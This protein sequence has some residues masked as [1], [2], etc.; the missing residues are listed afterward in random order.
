MVH[1]LAEFARLAA[2]GA[3]EHPGLVTSA[4]QMAVIDEA[5]RQTGIVFPADNA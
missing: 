1:E 5:R 4:V 2:A 3:V